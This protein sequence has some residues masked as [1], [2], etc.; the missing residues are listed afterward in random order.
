LR[1]AFQIHAGWDPW[2]ER[3]PDR[4]ELDFAG[5]VIPALDLRTPVFLVDFPDYEAS[6]ARTKPGDSSTVERLELFVGGLE[7]ANG[8]SEL[9]DPEEQRLRFERANQKRRFLGKDAY[10]WSEPFLESLGRMPPSAG[11]A[12]GMDRLVML[13]TD[14]ARIEDIVAFGSEDP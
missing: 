9:A 13:F 14:S 7:L 5:R 10:P 8:F 4:F 3:D 1:K 2:Q 12:L 11:I 6:L